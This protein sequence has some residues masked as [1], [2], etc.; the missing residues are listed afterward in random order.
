ML[1]RDGGRSWSLQ[2]AYSNVEPLTMSE[3]RQGDQ[4][5]SIRGGLG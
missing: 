2:L 5:P 3:R 1:V 4:G